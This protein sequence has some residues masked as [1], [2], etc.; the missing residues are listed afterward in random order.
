MGLAYA[1][2][3]GYFGIVKEATY[4]VAPTTGVSFCP[5]ADDV[6]ITLG[7]KFLANESLV[8]SPV[9]T[10]DQ[11]QGVRSDDITLKSPLYADTF[12]LF[13]VAALGGTDAVTGSTIYT[14]VIKL[15]NSA[16]TGS[17]S[18]SFTI[19]LFD[20]A[21]YWTMVGC[22][23]DTL[24]IPFSSDGTADATAK[25]IGNPATSGTSAPTGFTSPS[26]SSEVMVP[27]WSV[28]VTIA[29]VSIPYIQSGTLTI[30]RST[31]P[32][33]AEGSQ[34]A[35][36][37]FQ[38]PIKVTGKMTAVVATQADPWSAAS[39]AQALT[40]DQVATILTFTDPNDVTSATDH[41]ISFTMTKTQFMNPKRTQGKAY[42]EVESDF[43]G[44]ANAT[45]ATSG[46][47]PIQSTT[48]N[49]VSTA[50]N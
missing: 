11:V 34:T 48:L 18:P 24:E 40:R 27:G 29:T 25:F 14:H 2:R 26:F 46:V 4:A 13:I 17:Q 12:P 36:D 9:Q 7:Q 23:L 20:G 37:N 1:S 28:A 43:E 10:I 8:G 5:I 21:N 3:N 32:I 47:S 45:D 33:F 15:L 44:V 39:P 22:R 38:G 6:A 35:Y 42:V 16:S 49:A 41:S 50:Y 30:A 31:A 19:M